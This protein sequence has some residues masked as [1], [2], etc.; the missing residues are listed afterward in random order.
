M[1]TIYKHIRLDT[2]EIF[3]IGI[4]KQSN[5]AFS[6]QRRNKYWKSIV[7]KYGYKVEIIK[8][9]DTW[10]E[11]CKLE[12]ELISKYGR[13]DKGLGPL[14]NMTDGGEGSNGMS[15]ESKKSISEKLKVSRLGINN[16][17]YGKT[18]SLNPFFG[19]KHSKEH[20]EKNRIA[21]LGKR[22]RSES[23]K[24]KKVLDNNT[25]TIYDCVRDASEA[26]NMNYYTLVNMLSG[27]RINKTSLKYL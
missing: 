27:H 6:K 22:T 17:M 7:L 3:Y 24:A 10:E 21:H 2:N 16:P 14:V 8:E 11:A 1:A 18:G 15:E 23:C 5:R 4:G 26:N 25:N 9:V 13:K 20:I 12:I 19:K